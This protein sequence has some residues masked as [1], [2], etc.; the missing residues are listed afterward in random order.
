MEIWFSSKL[1]EP[2]VYVE[3]EQKGQKQQR[4]VSATSESESVPKMVRALS[5]SISGLFFRVLCHTLTFPKKNEHTQSQNMSW[6][7]VGVGALNSAQAPGVGA[8]NLN[9]PVRKPGRR[10]LLAALN[11]P[12]RMP[13]A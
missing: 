10:T 6:G 1:F 11:L 9:L 7:P 2:Q 4:R 3:S 13:F 5:S 8:L 12:L